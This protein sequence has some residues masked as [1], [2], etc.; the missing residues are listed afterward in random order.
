[1]VLKPLEIFLLKRILYITK[2]FIKMFKYYPVLTLLLRIEA[3]R[4]T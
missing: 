1:M 4:L 2:L 3:Q